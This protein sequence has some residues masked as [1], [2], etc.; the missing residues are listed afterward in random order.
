MN[1][2][3][4]HPVGQGLFYTGALLR[5]NYNFVFDCGSEERSCLYAA[6]EN[7]VKELNGKPIDFVVISHLHIDHFD[8]LYRLSQMAHIKKVYL[9]Y[10][11]DNRQFVR[12]ILAYYILL[13]SPHMENLEIYLFACRLYGV[14]DDER[15]DDREHA[16]DEVEFLGKYGEEIYGKRTDE[17]IESAGC[18]YS[19]LTEQ[20]TQQ[21]EP[22]WR[23]RFI[24]KRLGAEK[25]AALHKNVQDN[26]LKGRSLKDYIHDNEEN[27]KSVRKEYEQIFGKGNLLNLTSTVLVHCPAKATSLS[28]YFDAP[29]IDEEIISPLQSY[30]LS[31]QTSE[32]HTTIL[33]GD[34]K[35]DRVMAEEIY[36]FGNKNELGEPKNLILQLPHHGAY[37]NLIPIINPSD[38][39]A[40]KISAEQYVISFGLGNRHRHPN[41][42]TVSYLLDNALAHIYVTQE[43]GWR[44][45]IDD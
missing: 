36:Y 45:F 40:M 3:Y 33:T 34:A 11:G 8:G 44:Y 38:S 1:K 26:L 19:S 37:E 7:Y 22:Y 24:N 41:A 17:Q 12:D 14:A 23:F 35:I 21:G 4:F 15:I 5:G 16:I 25:I 31:P 29:N 9:P 42:K 2:F 27:I 6:I 18:T 43:A 30:L 32:N 13:D 20:L 39:P 10:L 28:Y